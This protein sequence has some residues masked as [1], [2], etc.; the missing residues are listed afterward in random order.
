[1]P[2]SSMRRHS[3]AP[4]KRRANEPAREARVTFGIVQQTEVGA[5]CVLGRI[6]DAAVRIDLEHERRAGLVDAKIAPTEAR[7]AERDE[8]TRRNVTQTFVE[9]WIGNGKR[10]H[11]LVIDPFHRRML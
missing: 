2:W 5:P 11:P 8:K 3:L 9:R 4:R 7:A 6:V 10:R 1:M